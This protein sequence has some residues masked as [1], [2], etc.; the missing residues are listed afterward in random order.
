MLAYTGDRVTS[1]RAV[2]NTSI[3]INYLR[4]RQNKTV[5]TTLE[6][7]PLCRFFYTY[8]LYNITLYP[9]TLLYLTLQTLV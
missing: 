6:P 9:F 7:A 2:Q 1:E 4:H 5:I 3:R 8:T